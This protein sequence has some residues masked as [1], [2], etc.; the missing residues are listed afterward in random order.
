MISGLVNGCGGGNVIFK[1]NLQV[2]RIIFGEKN[3]EIYNITKSESQYSTLNGFYERLVHCYTNGVSSEVINDVINICDKF[4]C[5]WLDNSC[6]GTLAKALIKHGFGGKIITFFH[7]VEY[8]FQ[9]RK[10]WQ[11]FL[12]FIYNRPIKISEKYATNYSDLIFVLNSRDYEIVRHSFSFKRIGILPSSINDN[13]VMPNNITNASTERSLE[14]LFVGTNFYAN[15]NGIIWFVKNILPYSNIHLTIIGKGMDSVSFPTSEKLTVYGYVDSLSSFYH[16]SDVVVAP[17][18]EGSGMKT[19]TTEAL[20]W[21]K[22]IIGTPEAFCG[23]D[24][25]ENQG[26]SCLTKDDFIYAIDYVRNKGI[27]SFVK[28]S[29]DLYLEKYSIRSS[30]DIIKRELKGL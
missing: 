16:K 23:F 11:R 20:M 15:T 6:Y 22:Y 12:Y 7:N 14:L 25:D 21:G 29:R 10:W 26:L 3:V 28:S 24:I 30:V 19:K 8:I 5:I 27:P 1:R 2:L 9:K 17:I 13:F 4:D 18:F